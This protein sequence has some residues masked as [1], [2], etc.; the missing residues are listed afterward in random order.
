M[1]WKKVIAGFLVFASALVSRATPITYK[2]IS[3]LLRNGEREQFIFSEAEKRKL[4]QPLSKQEEAVLSGLGATAALLNALRSPALLAPPDMVAAYKARMLPPAPGPQ[5]ATPEEAP[6][7]VLVA[8]P[9]PVPAVTNITAA[10]AYAKNAAPIGLMQNDAYSLAQIE[11]AKAKARAQKKPLGFIMVWSDFFGKRADPRGTGSTSALAHFYRAFDSSLV[12]VFVQHETELGAVPA[13]V[14][15]GFTGPDE[16]GFAPN[17]AVVDA[18]ATELIIEIPMGG[19]GV[20][21]AKRDEIF[22]T[23]AAKIEKWLETHPTATAGAPAKP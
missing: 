10:I 12:L 1:N 5:P 17:M 3:M 8:P 11:D 9:R 19:N 22:T 18:T 6:R 21:G 13:A 16:G 7:A 14:K 2:E 15:K 23:R 4:L 20:D